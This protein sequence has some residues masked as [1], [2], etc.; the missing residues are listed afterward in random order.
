MSPKTK[1]AEEPFQS[2]GDP[3]DK[4]SGSLGDPGLGNKEER[5]P[6]GQTGDVEI[7]TTDEKTV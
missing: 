6:L 3:Q 4:I 1:K 5:P 7:R 2:K